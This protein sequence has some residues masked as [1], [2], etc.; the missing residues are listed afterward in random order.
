MAIIEDL[1]I[2]HTHTN[3]QSTEKK[4]LNYIFES[5]GQQTTTS[6]TKSA[7]YLFL[8]TLLAKHSFPILKWLG[9]KS[10]EE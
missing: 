8:Y 4:T 7:G 1:K 6:G 2:T 10:K 9:K 5:K 3:I